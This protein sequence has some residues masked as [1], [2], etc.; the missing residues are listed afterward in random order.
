[1]AETEGQMDEPTD[2]GDSALEPYQLPVEFWDWPGVRAKSGAKSE[3]N[4][5]PHPS[6]EQGPGTEEA[7][8]VDE[9]PDLAPDDPSASA[10][11]A[12]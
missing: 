3:G 7:P 10:S 1:M 4:P 5:R 8:A 9:H 6:S 12:E 11:A 2:P